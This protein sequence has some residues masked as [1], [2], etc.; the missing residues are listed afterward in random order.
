MCLH[1]YAYIYFERVCGAGPCTC[2]VVGIF[3]D[4]YA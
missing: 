4:L 2:T 1:V 3:I